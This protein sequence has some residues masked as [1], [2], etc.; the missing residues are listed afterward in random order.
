MPTVTITIPTAIANR[1]IDGFCTR[2][3]YTPIL[4]DGTPNP[5]TQA[6]FVKRKIIEYIKQAVREAEIQTATNT[7]ATSAAE[8]ADTDI[9]IT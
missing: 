6:Q 3:N 8:S 7:A 1:V 2:Y 5:E 9:L 4:E